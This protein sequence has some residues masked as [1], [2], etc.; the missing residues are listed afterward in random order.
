[1]LME[2]INKGLLGA[3]DAQSWGEEMGDLEGQHIALAPTPII[4]PITPENHNKGKCMLAGH[5]V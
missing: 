5:P 4:T 3:C 2:P 1:M